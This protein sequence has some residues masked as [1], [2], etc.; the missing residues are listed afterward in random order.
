MKRSL[1]ILCSRGFCALVALGAIVFAP[2]I[3]SA[4][5]ITYTASGTDD[6][7]PISVALDFAAINGGLAITITNTQSGNMRIGRGISGLSFTVDGLSTPTAFSSLSGV[8]LN[9]TGDADGTTWTLSDGTSFS[10]GPGPIITHWAFSTS[11]S[12]TI[13]ASAGPGHPPGPVSYMILPSSG[14]VQGGLPTAKFNPFF[15]GPTVFDLTVP[16][17]TSSTTLTTA[18]FSDILVSFGTHPDGIL[19]VVTPEPSSLLLAGSILGGAIGF[20]FV[21]KLF[22]KRG[23]TPV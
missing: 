21:R 22:R 23:L 5:D 8:I 18:N 20:G 4:N 17:I 19:T 9:L 15:I 12:D 7:G 11:G 13:L 16:G 6:S 2:G 3:S 10:G 14:T 1:G